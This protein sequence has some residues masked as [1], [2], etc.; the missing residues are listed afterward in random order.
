MINTNCLTGI[1]C[2]V[3]GNE[4]KF[5]IRA[6]TLAT[7]TDDGIEDYAD[8]EWD[9]D[10]HAECTECLKAGKLRD[11]QMDAEAT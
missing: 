8:M 1:K 11:F 3:C 9:D 2:P 10:S 4:D 5:R 6:T 7:V